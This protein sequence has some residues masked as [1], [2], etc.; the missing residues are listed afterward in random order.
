MMQCNAWTPSVQIAHPSAVSHTACCHVC[1][2]IL[3][4]EGNCI[5]IVIVALWH[6]HCRVVGCEDEGD[7]DG[8]VVV[9]IALSCR[10]EGE[11]VPVEQSS[12]PL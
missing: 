9:V 12:V 1:C 10:V 7:G 11:E 8:I 2:C 5:V 6:C 3:E 4:R